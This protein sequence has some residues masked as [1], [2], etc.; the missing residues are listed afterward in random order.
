MEAS[1]WLV[2][3]VKGWYT[4]VHDNVCQ[5]FS[6]IHCYIF[7]SIHTRSSWQPHYVFFGSSEIDVQSPLNKHRALWQTNW[8]VFR[9]QIPQNYLFSYRYN[10]KPAYIIINGPVNVS[11]CVVWV[12]AWCGLTPTNVRPHTLIHR[13]G[14]LI[15]R[16][17]YSGNALPSK[18]PCTDSVPNPRYN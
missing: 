2:D 12:W 15:I 9:Q 7:H 13:P 11:D 1:L 16:T 17:W 5:S 4:R 3:K 14:S 6:F 18:W 10:E 8:M